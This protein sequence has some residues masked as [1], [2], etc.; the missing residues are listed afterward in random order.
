MLNSGGSGLVPWQMIGSQ[1]LSHVN[2][3]IVP[4]GFKYLW[5][6]FHICIC[7]VLPL[8]MLRMGA[9]MPS[10]LCMFLP[11]KIIKLWYDKVSMNKIWS[12]NTMHFIFG[13]H[14]RQERLISYIYFIKKQW[15]TVINKVMMFV[16]S[17]FL[18]F[19]W[20]SSEFNHDRH[21]RVLAGNHFLFI[22]FEH[23]CGNLGSKVARGVRVDQPCRDSNPRPSDLQPDAMTI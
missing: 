14:P 3:L 12:R 15:P 1:F 9:L 8:S 4:H 10:I 11:V 6:P 13:R 5:G 18:F 2:L 19:Y 23:F 21:F 16:C 22:F 17:C 20:V 7:L